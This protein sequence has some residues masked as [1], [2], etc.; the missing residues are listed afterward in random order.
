MYHVPLPCTMHHVSCTNV[1][2]TMYLYQYHVPCRGEAGW[3]AGCLAGCQCVCVRVC[4]SVSVRVHM[5][6]RACVRV[7]VCTCVPERVCVSSHPPTSS[8]SR[9]FIL[10]SSS[11]ITR[12]SSDLPL[13]L[14]PVMNSRPPA[15]TSTS[16]EWKRTRFGSPSPPGSS[17]RK[18]LA[19]K[20]IVL[21]AGGTRCSVRSG[22]QGSELGHVERRAARSVRVERALQE[23]DPNIG[24]KS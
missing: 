1:P 19:T 17:R 2:C 22:Q 10:S 24:A 18:P 13:P 21:S 8:L 6:A 16:S 9:S 23:K 14:R 20:A 4:V 3:W 7:S 15:G 11:A 12:S 5:R